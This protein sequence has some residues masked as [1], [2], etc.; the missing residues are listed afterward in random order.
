MTSAARRSA[1][2]PA[3]AMQPRSAVPK[4]THRIRGPWF[5]TE[6]KDAGRGGILKNPSKRE[7]LTLA[8]PCFR[9][10]TGFSHGRFSEK[11]PKKRILITTS[12]T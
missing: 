1:R 4:F 9:G 3:E 5:T 12:T 10:V 8:R 11:S 2:F 7:V 6:T